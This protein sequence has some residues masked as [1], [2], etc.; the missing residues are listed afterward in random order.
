MQ[1][2]ILLSYFSI[3]LNP[4]LYLYI[5]GKK[6]HS[7]SLKVENSSNSSSKKAFPSSLNLSLR[8]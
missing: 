2:G 3:K 8:R 6:L 5:K 1:S 7:S 4:D